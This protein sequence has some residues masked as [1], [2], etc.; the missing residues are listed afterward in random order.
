[1]SSP[2]PIFHYDFSSPYAYLAAHRVDDVLPLPV[3][4][5]PIAFG[6]LLKMIGKTPWSFVRDADHDERR[7]DCERR[8]AALG[9]DLKW[10]E[11]WPFDSY[12]MRVLRAAVVAED[13]GLLREFSLAA[14]RHGFGEGRSLRELDAVLAVAA[15]VGLD[16]DAVREG[17]EDDG[18]KT[19][20]RMR[21]EHARSIGVSGLP[22]VL[23]GD[24]LFW[25]DDRLEDAAEVLGA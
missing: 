11:G 12:S 18:V 21:T 2:G 13:A 5:M 4:W 24:R 7:R 20:L 23:V 9:L 19:R 22:T 3:T 15:D 10:P 17:V 6:P 14:F 8:A 16:L 25:G 1:M